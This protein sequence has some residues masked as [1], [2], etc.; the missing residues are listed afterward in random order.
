MDSTNLP[1]GT[2]PINPHDAR[3]LTD[4]IREHLSTLQRDFA[5][6]RSAHEHRRRGYPTWRAFVDQE[7]L[8]GIFAEFPPSIRGR[9]EAHV[10]VLAYDAGL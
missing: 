3:A 4:G 1:T 6:L 8:A 10:R 5:R 9:I 7:L 2:L